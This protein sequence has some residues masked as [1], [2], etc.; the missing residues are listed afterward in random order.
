MIDCPDKLW[1]HTEIIQ[2]SVYLEFEFRKIKQSD[3]SN[4]EIWL[5]YDIKLVYR[6]EIDF[7]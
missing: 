3:D 2:N 5:F 4:F 6:D 1:N 7:K